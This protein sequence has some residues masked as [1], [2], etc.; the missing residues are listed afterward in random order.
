MNLR[1]CADFGREHASRV[2][3]TSACF[4][5]HAQ[6]QVDVVKEL[7]NFRISDK[8]RAVAHHVKHSCTRS[9]EA[10]LGQNASLHSQCKLSTALQVVVTFTSLLNVRTPLQG[11][12]GVLKAWAAEGRELF[13]QQFCN[14]ECCR[15]LA[16][17]SAHPA[18]LHGVL[19]SCLRVGEER[20][21][22]G[23]RI[24]KD[25]CVISKL[26]HFGFKV[27]QAI[28]GA[29]VSVPGDDL[30]LL[31]QQQLIQLG[32]GFLVTTLELVLSAQLSELL[33]KARGRE[34]T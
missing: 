10:V 2:T 21:F 17:C 8:V 28:L 31:F 19:P 26:H 27:L 34:S 32:L 6:L 22:N 29:L 20:L 5:R 3:E 16:A 30:Q 33:L 4:V 18:L 24:D 23:H 1:L 13:P 15:W 25:V 14:C 7:C 11:Q 12:N 9:L